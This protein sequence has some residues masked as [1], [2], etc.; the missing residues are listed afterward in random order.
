MKNKA[1]EAIY[2]LSRSA[3]R[4]VKG[5]LRPIVHRH[6]R[7]HRFAV[8][9]KE[10]FKGLF[11]SSPDHR[12][13]G[14]ET[15]HMTE[16]DHTV[17]QRDVHGRRDRFPPWLIDEWREIHAIEPQL[18]PDFS[19]PVEVVTDYISPSRVGEHYLDLYRLFGASVSHVILTPWLKKG[20][21][22]LVTLNLVRA[23]VT[24]NLATGV[25]VV[26]TERDDSP[27]AERLP[28]A[29]R[30]IEFGKRYG[31]LKQDEQEK[32]LV[33]V[34]L[35]MAPPVI[36]TINSL[37]GYRVFITYGKALASRSRLYA[38][39]FC[40]D[41]TPEGRMIGYPIC[42]LPHCFD[43]LTAVV[44]ENRTIIDKLCGIFAF[45]RGKFHV[46]YQPVDPVSAREYD[47]GKTVKERMDILWAS[48]LDIQKRPDIL[49]GIAEACDA[50]RLPFTFHVY[51][52]P[53]YGTSHLDADRFVTALRT[54][55]NVRYQGGFEGLP[56]LPADQ[57]DLFLYT[58]QWD[59]IPN[60]I[61]EAI[62]MGLPVIASKTGGIPEVI[63]DGE[64]G[65]IVDPYDDVGGYVRRLDGIFADRQ[66]LGRIARHARDLIESR[67]SW[68]V[69]AEALR[70]VPGYVMPRDEP[71]KK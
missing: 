17:P 51:G 1:A 37:L 36:H 70:T 42:F 71:A 38:S 66:V 39:A 8:A 50:A 47:P 58:S 56:S 28:A 33:R 21:A 48:R 14:A 34:L 31:H 32:L 30:F 2:T 7:V 13:S 61:L 53:V 18:F 35:Q 54:L 49:I 11:D 29:V 63:I 23:L 22:E 69:Y 44:T 16:Q 46:Q 27:W 55:P 24:E 40:E 4:A 41:V 67:H 62:S 65:F 64:T 43:A 26:T 52:T 5:P 57:Y 59:G 9:L 12:E 25:V 60:V 15:A 20:G 19:I 3:Y 68:R 45:D 6:P 10:A